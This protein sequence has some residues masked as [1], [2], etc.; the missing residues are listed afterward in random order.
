MIESATS[1][2]VQVDVQETFAATVCARSPS[3]DIRDDEVKEVFS[4]AG[5]AVIGGR[6]YGVVNN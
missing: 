3:I 2:R 5:P 1:T 4:S 6:V